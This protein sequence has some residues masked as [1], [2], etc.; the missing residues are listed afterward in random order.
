M[1]RIKQMFS[2]KNNE[3]LFT[4]HVFDNCL[5]FAYCFFSPHSCDT[6]VTDNI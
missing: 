6:P 1:S 5:I 4:L 2:E 3:I